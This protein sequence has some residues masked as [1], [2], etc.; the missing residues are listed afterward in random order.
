MI[1][2]SELILIFILLIIAMP[3]Y[4]LPSILARDRNNFTPILLTNILLGWTVIGWIS[5]LVWALKTDK[6]ALRMY[7]SKTLDCCPKMEAELIKLE[8][9]FKAGVITKA[10]YYDETRKLI[11]N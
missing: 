11:E 8:N 3:L 4:L 5:S 2:Y 6:N 1:G 9:L 10:D 7:R